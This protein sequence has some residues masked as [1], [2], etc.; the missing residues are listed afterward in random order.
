MLGVTLCEVIQL[1][2]VFGQVQVWRSLKS[3]WKDD[4]VS[5]AFVLRFC[6]FIGRLV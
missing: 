3:A 6:S 1:D 4:S 2:V 5:L